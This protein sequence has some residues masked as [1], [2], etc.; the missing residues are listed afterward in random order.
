MSGERSCG[1][2]GRLS[3]ARGGGASGPESLCTH[4]RQ[5][6]RT[7]GQAAD[8]AVPMRSVRLPH[9]LCSAL[10]P[11]AALPLRP[12][13]S[14]GAGT[15]HLCSARPDVLDAGLAR[16]PSQHPRSGA[17]SRDLCGLPGSVPRAPAARGSTEAPQRPLQA[18]GAGWSSP[19]RSTQRSATRGSAGRCG[20]IRSECGGNTF[21]MAGLEPPPCWSHR[22]ATCPPH[23]QRQRR[24]A[25]SEGVQA[26]GST[27]RPPWRPADAGPTAG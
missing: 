13:A 20:V 9:V 23:L 27:T 16:L 22:L 10:V 11:P 26:W 24:D 21:W 3:E 12:M 2:P 19:P 17:A 4:M 1:A 18:P 7:R 15:E 8:R 6:A 14:A 5:R 25:P